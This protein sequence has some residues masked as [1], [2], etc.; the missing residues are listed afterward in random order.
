MAARRFTMQAGEWKPFGME[1]RHDYNPEEQEF[2]YTAEYAKTGRAGCKKCG[3]KIDKD[4]VRIGNPIKWRGGGEFGY[5]NA[6]HH[7]GCTRAEEKSQAKLGK[8]IY[9]LADL[10]P[11]VRES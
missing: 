5:I 6:W 8:L 1:D 11:K 10:K 4:T 9:G 2:L 3:E 7:P